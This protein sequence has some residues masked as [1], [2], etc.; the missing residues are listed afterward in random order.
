MEVPEGQ[1]GSGQRGHA[2]RDEAR[3]VLQGLGPKIHGMRS[4]LVLY[5]QELCLGSRAGHWPD[6]CFL[7]FTTCDVV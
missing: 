5:Q 7:V 6:A 4:P 2:M 3:V 1:M